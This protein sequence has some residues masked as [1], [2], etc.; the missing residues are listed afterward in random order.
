MDAGG[1]LKGAPDL[2]APAPADP[3]LDQTRRIWSHRDLFYRFNWIIAYRSGEIRQQYERRGETIFQT[4]FAKIP[5]RGISRILVLDL[6]HPILAF[7]V[8]EEAEADILYDV[9][10]SDPAKPH[11]I[12]VFGFRYPCPFCVGSRMIGDETCIKCRG[13][14]LD[15]T[16]PPPSYWHIDPSTEPPRTL[17]N[18]S[19][20][21]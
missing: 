16:C 9:R 14:G 2:P 3:L 11:R 8:P 12:F 18:R 15:L 19:R 17:W 1:L 21:I 13:T 6:I 4:L 10:F 5:H 20:I 7:D